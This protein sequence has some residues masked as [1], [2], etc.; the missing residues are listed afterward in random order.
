MNS[1]SLTRINYWSI[2]FS[3]NRELIHLFHELTM[4]SFLFLRFTMDHYHFREFII[5]LLSVT[6]IN[7][8]FTILFTNLLCF[9]FS[10][11]KKNIGIQ[12]WFLFRKFTIDS[13][14][15]TQIQHGF[16]IF[17]ISFLWY[18]YGS[19]NFFVKSLLINFLFREFNM[20]LL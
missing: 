14:S 3:A 11:C 17:M 1:L 2:M 16:N 18:Q 12:N 10:F 9:N 19:I 13:L 6:L 20:N 8:E 7:L 15:V 5:N 4:N